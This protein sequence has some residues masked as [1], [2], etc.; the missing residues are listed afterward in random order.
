M[1][2]LLLVRHDHESG[3]SIK[4]YGRSPGGFRRGAASGLIAS[5][6]LAVAGCAGDSG[7]EDRSTW[8]GVDKAEQSVRS[9]ESDNRRTSPGP[10]VSSDRRPAAILANESITWAD[11]SAPLAE[12]A[13]GTV[14]EE[15]ALDRIIAKE[16]QLRGFTLEPGAGTREEEYLREALA[17]AAGVQAGQQGDL[18]QQLRRSRGL[19]DRRYASLLDRNAKLRRM[20]RDE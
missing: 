16:M 13:G 1:T 2:I 18:V 5:S 8:K 6:L 20:V 19:G 15:V 7:P 3:S 4:G 11:L 12:A 17:I 10:A 9:A 14:L